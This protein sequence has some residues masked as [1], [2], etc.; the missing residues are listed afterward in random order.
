MHLGRGLGRPNGLS[1]PIWVVYPGKKFRACFLSWAGCHLVM[2]RLRVSSKVEIEVGVDKGGKGATVAPVEGLGTH[3]SC[4]KLRRRWKISPL[5]SQRRPSWLGSTRCRLDD[6]ATV[7]HHWFWR[8]VLREKDRERA[9]ART[10]GK[11]KGKDDGLTPEQRRE[12]D[13]K[14]LQEKTAKKAAGEAAG[15]DATGGKSTKK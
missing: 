15:G 5:G 10:G 7:Y 11:G 8:L 6:S 3:R 2:E 13:A 1:I 14:A 9:S 12:R 4:R